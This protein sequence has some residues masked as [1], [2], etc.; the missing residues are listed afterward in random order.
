MIFS[1]KDKSM[2]IDLG[3]I[4][5]GDIR[6]KIMNESLDDLDELSCMVFWKDGTLKYK[7]VNRLFTQM[8]G[9]GGLAAY[10]GLTDYQ[11]Y[12][13]SGGYGAEYFQQCDNYAMKKSSM[14]NNIEV[15]STPE[16]PKLMVSVSK[17]PLLS[18]MGKV[19]GVYCISVPIQPPVPVNQLLTAQKKLT[20]MQFYVLKL[21]LQGAT[22][23][24]IARKID[25]SHR[26]VEA[27]LTAIKSRLDCSDRTELYTLMNAPDF[28]DFD[29]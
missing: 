20:K 15:I 11:L 13:Q 12:W 17:F 8:L 6:N 2:S 18:K 28:R 25:R 21:Y 7:G 27:H 26:T 1:G 10:E 24:Q 5:H 9:G 23:K 16:M 4:D 3:L 22:A 19:V 29:K 14:I